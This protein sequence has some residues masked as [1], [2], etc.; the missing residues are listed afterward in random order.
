M[1]DVVF[2]RAVEHTLEW[3]GGF[4]D[5]PDDRGGATAFG[6]S[7]AWLRRAGLDLDVRSI[8]REKAIE[9]YHDRFWKPYYFSKWGPRRS[10]LAVK[11]FD[12]TVLNGPAAAA[13]C[14]QRA[15]RACGARGLSDDGRFGSKSEAALEECLSVV[16]LPAVLAAY[17]EALASRHRLVA[18]L[19]PT[20]DVFLRGWL[21]R[22]YDE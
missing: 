18:E 9:L 7:S 21:R 16:G 20:Q 2:R 13:K 22:E 17:R 11:A 15:L 5:H 4:V 6:I 3:E 19:N 10:D 12:A 1:T 8:T 14:L